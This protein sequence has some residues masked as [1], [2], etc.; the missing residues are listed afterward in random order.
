[1][2]Y[3]AICLLLLVL[4]SCGRTPTPP[5]L[6]VKGGTYPS[7]SGRYNL[8]VDVSGNGIVSYSV[9]DAASQAALLSDGGFSTYQ[10]WCFYWD[11][12]DR[13]WTYNSDMGPFALWS[14]D[15][16][17]QWVRQ[18][19]RAGSPLLAEVPGPVY[20]F[21]PGSLKKVLGIEHGLPAAP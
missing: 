18:D 2:R 16:G 4:A 21:L 1:M 20:D 8:V 13:L 7:P 17:G 11:R 3:T 12:D 10:R 6:V 14:V 9:S 15:P 19:I 5:G